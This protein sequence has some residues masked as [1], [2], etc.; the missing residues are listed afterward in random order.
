MRDDKQIWKRFR[1]GRKKALS[2]IYMHN[3][4]FLLNYGLKFTNDRELVLDAIQDLF[5]TLMRTREN[6]GE[7]EN[8][9]LYLVKALRRLIVNEITKSRKT[10][11]FNESKTGACDIVFSVE[12]QIIKRDVMGTPNA[13]MQDGSPRNYFVI[14]FEKNNYHLSFKGVGLDRKRQM[15]IWISKQDTI[16]QHI[17]KLKDMPSGVVLANIY[18]ACDSTRVFMK[19]NSG[20]WTKLE[21]I[22]QTDPYVNRTVSFNRER[23][24]PS[25]YSRKIPM[26]N[27]PS[28]H[29][30]RGTIHKPFSE[31]I[32]IIQIEASDNYGF[33]ATGQLLF[34]G[35]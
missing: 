7:T 6:L 2:D 31:K 20:E 19:I 33:D 18:G 12:E 3:I 28:P 29:L 11:D 9:R 30:W 26:R 35:Q 32:S 22:H 15:T 24:Y 8:I 16:D 34:I 10:T 21:L 1:R 5:L 13:L 25:R 23:V 14:D 4:D 17:N 27:S